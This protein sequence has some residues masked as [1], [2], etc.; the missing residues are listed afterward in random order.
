MPTNS[1]WSRTQ[2]LVPFYLYCCMP[3]GKIHRLNPEIIR[4]ATAIGRTPSALAMKMSNIA[5]LDLAITSTGH[6][7]HQKTEQHMAEHRQPSPTKP[8][9]ILARNPFPPT[10]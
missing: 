3:F 5:S 1:A 9:A 10:P 8:H 6:L 4:M 7:R 2:L